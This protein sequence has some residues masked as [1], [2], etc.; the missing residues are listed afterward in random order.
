M[1]VNKWII[2]FL[3]IPALGISQVRDSAYHY[4]N[5]RLRHFTIASSIA[6]SATLVGLN[7]LWYNGSPKQHFRF[8]NDHKEWKQVDKLGHL[9]S[10]FYLSYA[11]ARA[12][13]WCSLPQRKANIAGSIAGFALLLPIEV[14][15]GFSEAYGASVGDIVANAAGSSLYLFQTTLWQEIRIQ[16]K[17]SFTPSSY[18]ALRPNLL[19]KNLSEEILKDY[20]GQTYWLSIDAD[21]FIRFPK[22]L[23]IAFGYGAN[24][25]IYARSE[26]NIQAGYPG[27]YRQFYVSLDWDL[28]AINTK[29]KAVRTL[30]FIVNMLKLPAPT[31]EV[32]NKTLTFHTLHF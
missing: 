11:T 10:S 29:S 12:L 15:D 23:N 13:Q 28:T 24:G 2:L 7:N 30:L 21:K 3:F 17:F 9:Y 5:K 27:H 19:G 31:L 18:A 1:E 14:F 20:N 6:Y 16:P 32:S 22:W 4:N 26:Q 8:F 25:M